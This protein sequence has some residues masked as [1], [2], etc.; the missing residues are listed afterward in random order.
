MPA[1]ILQD[2]CD[3]SSVQGSRS[4]TGART[5]RIPI[6]A[7]LATLVAMTLAACGDAVAVPAGQ[8]AVPTRSA[9]SSAPKPAPAKV[10]LA[11]P[12]T[13]GSTS[14]QPAPTS[15]VES[16]TDGDD[17]TVAPVSA[18][19]PAPRPVA[20]SNP[21][22]QLPARKG[23]RPQAGRD[24]SEGDR[25]AK[26]AGRAGK[27]KASGVQPGAGAAGTDRAVPFRGR[28]GGE[29]EPLKRPENAPP[30]KQRDPR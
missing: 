21:T 10:V 7:A 12:G 25:P 4:A 26:G 9:A 27:Q 3:E 30:P 15:L 14:S 8:A 19:A 5:M 20:S 17:A 23:A 11:A 6:T 16:G 2:D 22:I 18:A 29:L 13:G 1:W 24:R 28:K